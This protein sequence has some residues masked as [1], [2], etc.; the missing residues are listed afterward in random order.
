METSRV[1][2]VSIPESPFDF[3]SF[4]LPIFSATKD[5]NSPLCSIVLCHSCSQTNTA[6][7]SQATGIW[8]GK[9]GILAAG[10]EHF[11][12]VCLKGRRESQ[13][14]IQLR[15]RTRLIDRIRNLWLR[16][17]LLFHSRNTL[18]VKIII[19]FLLFYPSLYP[20]TYLT[21]Y[22]SI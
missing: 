19:G 20:L 15:K 16:K 12:Q 5:I 11:L 22:R 18:M 14:I 9:C 21:V 10:S 17:S 1:I 4:I 13:P 8:M 2:S 7:S 3:I 6:G